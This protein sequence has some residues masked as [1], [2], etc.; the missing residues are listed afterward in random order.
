M[1]NTDN[2]TLFGNMPKA[3]IRCIP[4][5]G[6]QSKDYGTQVFLASKKQNAMVR[7]Y[8]QG[9]LYSYN[10]APLGEEFTLIAYG[11]YKGKLYAVS[12]D[13]TIS[14]NHV[15]E[16]NMQETTEQ[17]LEKMIEKLDQ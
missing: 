12:K 10:Y 9:D 14:N 15:V 1:G 13:F 16:F 3:N 2:P 4:H 6:Q 7:L 17:M 11:A 5:P 8:L